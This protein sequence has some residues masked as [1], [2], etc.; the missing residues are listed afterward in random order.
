MSAKDEGNCLPKMRVGSTLMVM[1]RIQF[2]KS[3][4]FIEFNERYGN[5]VLCEKVLF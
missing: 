4:S 3:S 1:N 5:E 2:Q